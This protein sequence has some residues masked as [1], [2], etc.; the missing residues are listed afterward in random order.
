MHV[1]ETY[2]KKFRQVLKNGEVQNTYIHFVDC[3]QELLTV[4][5]QTPVGAA[6]GARGA[7]VLIWTGGGVT[8]AGVTG[9]GVLG[10]LVPGVN[11]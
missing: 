5:M 2:I 9:D 4:V 10:A 11:S 3:M 6:V 1:I 8:G 7:F